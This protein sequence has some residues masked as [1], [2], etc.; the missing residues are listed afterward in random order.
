VQGGF[1]LHSHAQ[2]KYS[3]PRISFAVPFCGLFRS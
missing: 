1:A 3:H 2:K